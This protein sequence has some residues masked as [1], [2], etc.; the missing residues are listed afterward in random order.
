MTFD[1]ILDRAVWGAQRVSKLPADHLRVMAEAG[2]P[3]IN[4]QVS[5]A[6]AAKEDSRSL[7]RKDVPLVFVGGTISIPDSVLRK[8]LQDST[9]VLSTGETASL[10]EPYADFLRVR[11]GR[12]PWWAYS[13]LLISAKNSL[14][15]GGGAYAGNATFTCIASPDVPAS[16]S[17]VYSAPADMVPDVID[18]LISYLAGKSENVAA[19][20]TA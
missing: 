1:E 15:Q 18:A 14:P 13:N 17:V 20:E 7:L 12:L 16:A 19:A 10:I 9:L 6:Y 11:D 3:Q 8:Y 2:F 4:S 5:E